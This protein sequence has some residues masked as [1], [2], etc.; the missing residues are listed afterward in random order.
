MCIYSGGHSGGAWGCPPYQG[1]WVLQEIWE[2][3]LWR[4]ILRKK[5]LSASAALNIAVQHFRM[6]SIYEKK[7]LPIN[8]PVFL[9]A[10]H[11]SP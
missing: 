8:F 3:H 11:H 4:L 2:A 5:V 10:A 1:Q 6:N 7:Y 9:H